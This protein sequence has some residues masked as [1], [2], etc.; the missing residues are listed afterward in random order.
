MARA[1]G[2]T[3]LGDDCTEVP[4]CTQWHTPSFLDRHI[5]VEPDYGGPVNNTYT[6]NSRKSSEISS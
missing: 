5:V 6:S 4:K 3:G 1:G 2:L